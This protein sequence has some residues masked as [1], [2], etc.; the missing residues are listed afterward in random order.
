MLRYKRLMVGLDLTAMDEVLI[1]TAAAWQELTGAEKIYFVHVGRDLYW[2]E[3]IMQTLPSEGKPI[4]ES[5]LAAMQAKVRA[6][7]GEAPKAEIAC[8]VIEGSPLAQLTHWAK[9]KKIDLI[10]VGKNTRSK[11][12]G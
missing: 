4:D 12:P 1:R 11:V 9:V 7:F 5:L 8:E 2:P 6:V 3:G 10:L